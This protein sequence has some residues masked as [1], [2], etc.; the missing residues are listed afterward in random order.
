MKSGPDIEE[1]ALVVQREVCMGW[2]FMEVYLC[3]M[4]Y[5]EGGFT[6]LHYGCID[7]WHICVVDCTELV[8]EDGGEDE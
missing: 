8:L 7:R 1:V 5:C 2:V 6:L 4:G 3:C